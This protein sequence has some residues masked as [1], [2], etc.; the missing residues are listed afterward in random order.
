MNRKT[1]QAETVIERYIHEFLENNKAARLIEGDL[2]KAG[3]GLRPLV[4]HITVRTLD[5]NRRAG[6]FIKLGF[7][8]D[9]AMGKKGIIEYE[10]WWAKVYRRPGLPA[11][12]IDQAFAGKK[13]TTS[14]IP[15]WVRRFSDQVLHHIALLVDDIEHAVALLKKK[16]VPFAGSIVGERGSDLRQV[17]TAADTKNGHPFTVLEIIERH[18]G[19][20]GFQPPQADSLMKAST[21]TA[22][23]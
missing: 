14:I 17:F 1:D 6:E 11:I 20:T 19:Y 16:G 7:R 5:V 12:F 15:P 8:W 4:D 21:L 3:I 13:G 18:R 22:R 2:K 9:K 23:K 10:D